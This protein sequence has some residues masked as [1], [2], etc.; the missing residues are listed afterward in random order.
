[1]DVINKSLLPSLFFHSQFGQCIVTLHI[2]SHLFS[3]FFFPFPSYVTTHNVMTSARHSVSA[4]PEPCRSVPKSAEAFSSRKASML[5][6]INFAWLIRAN[7]AEDRQSRFAC[8]RMSGSEVGWGWGWVGRGCVGWGG[9]V[10]GT[11]TIL[12]IV[13]APEVTSLWHLC[14]GR[15]RLSF[16]LL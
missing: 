10:G 16:A 15:Q 12:Q 11:D 13:L 6:R 8:S 5:D 14:L 7:F 2:T 9:E 3:S 4:F 1:M